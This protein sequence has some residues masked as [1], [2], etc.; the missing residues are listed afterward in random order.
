MLGYVAGMV[1]R[2][3]SPCSLSTLAEVISGGSYGAVAPSIGIYRSAPAIERFMRA[4]NE[5]FRVGAG[6]RV[7]TL[8]SFLIEI[9]HE[10]DARERL[11]YIIEQAVNPADF[12]REPERFQAA[13]TA[14]NLA[15][16]Q[17]G[18]ELRHR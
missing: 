12:A 9:N 18:L 4:C 13:L 1:G 8:E 3:L 14:M 17:D 5:N 10:H 6:S 16:I 15:L 7:P 11:T 2:F